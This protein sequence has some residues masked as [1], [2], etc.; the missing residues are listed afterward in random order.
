METIV[1]EKECLGDDHCYAANPADYDVCGVQQYS[2]I[3]HGLS[4]GN[5]FQSLENISE[6]L[7][8][9]DRRVVARLPPTIN[10][11]KMV[12]IYVEG[13]IG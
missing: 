5:Y 9:E 10:Q 7:G 12:I 8:E 4:S 6:L 11:Q 13:N 3:H 1:E 2:A